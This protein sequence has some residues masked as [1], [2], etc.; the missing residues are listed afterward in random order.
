MDLVHFKLYFLLFLGSLTLAAQNIEKMYESGEKGF[1]K[2]DFTQAQMALQAV[3]DLNP[4]YKDAKYMLEIASLLLKE[5]STTS[6]DEILRYKATKGKSDKFYY[7]WLG[8]VF[9][10]RYMFTEAIASW[11]SFLKSKAPKSP[12]IVAETNLF[13]LEN[14]R[15]NS[16]RRNPCNYSV[17]R[18]DAPINSVRGE[19]TPVYISETDELI[20]ASAAASNNDEFKIYSSK[21]V[22]EI[23]SEPVIIHSLGSFDRL[24]ANIEVIN[25]NQKLFLYKETKKGNL[26]FSQRNL[27]N[28]SIPVEF[29]SKITR[30]H[31]SSQFHINE[32]EDRIIFSSFSSLKLGLGLYESYRDAEKGKWSKPVSFA[33]EI[34]TEWNEDSPYLS[35]DESKLY[36][37]S[38]KDGGMGG[39]DIYVTTLNPETSKWSVPENLGW[40]INSPDDEFH[41]KLNDDEQSGYFI[42]NRISTHGD[43]DIFYFWDNDKAAVRGQILDKLTGYPITFGVIRFHSPLN[44][45]ESF[46][47]TLSE[48]GE[49]DVKVYT[50][51]EFNVELIQKTDT[52]F[53][54]SFEVMVDDNEEVTHIKDFF[55]YENNT[56]LSDKRF[57]ENTGQSTT[58]STGNSNQLS[59]EPADDAYDD[60][61]EDFEF[62][63]T[64]IESI[65]ELSSKFRVGNKVIAENIYFDFGTSKLNNESLPTLKRLLRLLKK[66]ESILVEIAGHSDN[67]GNAETNLKTS[68]KRAENVMAWL[69]GRGI[70]KDRLIA[71]GYGSLQPIAT[72]DD[73]EEGRE[74]NRRIEIRRLNN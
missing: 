48:R 29:D 45:G 32:H 3:V 55:I 25:N 14:Y 18:L 47:S 64:F 31:L 46:T 69:V 20:F 60:T 74:L 71:K 49:Y 19:M 62:N 54:E 66:N 56:D 15:L 24:S 42:S 22:S 4:N 34:D 43:Y 44:H 27:D 58:A 68:T 23:W 1:Y 63:E 12:Q 17:K 51:Q 57:G 67:I 40:P 10:K 52:I 7:Y 2:E 13:I 6:L 36:F 61:V 21:R 16:F 41:F 35:L 39:F 70:S 11:E 59:V 65:E 37:S 73:E 72:N 8:R 50:N 28:W 9:S 5:N 53:I 26:Y 38:D 30:T 33:M